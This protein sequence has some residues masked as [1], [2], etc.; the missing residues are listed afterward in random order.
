MD[1]SGNPVAVYQDIEG[2]P[3]SAQFRY[4]KSGFRYNLVIALVLTAAVCGLVWLLLGIYGSNHMNLYTALTGA[5][6]FAFI[7]ARMLAQY[8]RDEVVLAVQPTG[9]YDGRI[10]LET[11][12][13]DRIKELV[14]LR[15][16]QEYQLS[17]ILWPQKPGGKAVTHEINLTALEGGSQAILE[18][19]DQY[20]TI[21][22]ER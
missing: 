5:V 16:E 4:S 19:I 17:I 9:L 18:A 10:S 6:F 22:L 14:L 8:W 20:K 12:P 15:R 3:T 1:G 2:G 13:W 7:S 21:R 11:I